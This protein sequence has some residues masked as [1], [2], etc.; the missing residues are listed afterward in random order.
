M[1]KVHF[2]F[3]DSISPKTRFAQ[4]AKQRPKRNRRALRLSI[5][6]SRGHDKYVPYR[7]TI[8]CI[9]LTT[10]DNSEGQITANKVRT[11]H[12]VPLYMLSLMVHARNSACMCRARIRFNSLTG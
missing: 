9:A 4:N 8:D 5:L 6:A 7:L 2:N 12:L 10:E 1:S 11:P 3:I